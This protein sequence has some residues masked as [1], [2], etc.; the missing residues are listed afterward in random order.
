MTGKESI[1]KVEREHLALE[2]SRK[3]RQECRQERQERILVAKTTSDIRFTSKKFETAPA[4]FPNNDVKY[5]VNKLRSHSYATRRGVGLMYCPAK[6]TPTA[7]AL[8]ERPDLPS[9]KV[10]WLNRHDRESGDLYGILPLMK[11]LPVAM[12]DH[13]DRS[14]D[15]RILRGRIGK[16]DSWVLADDEKSVFENGKRIF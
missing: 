16:V 13:I 14:S 5:E 4:V 11:G 9:Q 6:D 8:R 2:T 10:S 1:S 12:T 3:E 15:K 7:D